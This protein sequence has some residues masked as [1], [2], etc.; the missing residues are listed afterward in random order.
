MFSMLQNLAELG[1]PNDSLSV[2]NIEN[3]L[4]WSAR[5]CP[6]K[7]LMML[8]SFTMSRRQTESQNKLFTE[9]CKSLERRWV[10]IK[11]EK[12]IH[13]VSHLPVT[14]TGDF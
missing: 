8:L 3:S 9:I 2:L 11:G 4:M 12:R 14:T 5:S 1:I 10:E 7:D 6:I 13:F